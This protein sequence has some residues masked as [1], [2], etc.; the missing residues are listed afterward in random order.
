MNEEMHF[1]GDVMERLKYN[2]SVEYDITSFPATAILVFLV[3]MPF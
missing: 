1:F 3:I 2:Q